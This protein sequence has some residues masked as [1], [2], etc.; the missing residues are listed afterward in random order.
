MFVI[1]VKFVI[2]EKDIEKYYLENEIYSKEER[3][4]I[5]LML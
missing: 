3:V 4:L 1:T 2:H 5:V